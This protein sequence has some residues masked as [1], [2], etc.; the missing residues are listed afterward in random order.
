MYEKLVTSHNKAKNRT[1]T[2]ENKC[3]VKNGM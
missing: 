3:V 1:E 2:G